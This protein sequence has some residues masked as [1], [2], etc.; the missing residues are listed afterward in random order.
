MLEVAKDGRD[1]GVDGGAG[2]VRKGGVEAVEL[3]HPHFPAFPPPAVGGEVDAVGGEPDD[4]ERE[5]RDA[6][7]EGDSARGPG[8]AI[9]NY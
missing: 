2:G 9:L 4:P 6:E 5:E 3:F 1:V 7:A 8:S